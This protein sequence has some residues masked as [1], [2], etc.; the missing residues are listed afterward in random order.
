MSEFQNLNLYKNLNIFHSNV[1]GLEI[2]SNNQHEFLSCS[3][4]NINFVAFTETSQTNNENFIQNVCIDEYDLYSTG[5]KSA[6]GG[7][8]IYVN[9]KFNSFERN[10]I[11]IKNDEFESVWIELNN[12]SSKNIICGC[13][14][15]HPRNNLKEFLSYLEKCLSIN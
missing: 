3:P 1:N 13:L 10:D 8:V 12:K 15:R 7:K 14:Y 4:F 6:R 2:N 11:K 9:N 5:S